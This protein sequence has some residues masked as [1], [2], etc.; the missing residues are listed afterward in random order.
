MKL[1]VT[2]FL[3]T[4]ETKKDDRRFKI[5]K[6]LISNKKD[7]NEK[8]I[9]DREMINVRRSSKNGML[10]VFIILMCGLVYLTMD[11]AK[12]HVTNVSEGK[13]Q[14][15]MEGGMPPDRPNN[16]D[17]NLGE[18]PSGNHGE[19]KEAGTP[20]QKPEEDF[21]G[22]DGNNGNDN[23]DNNANGEE[24]PE[25]PDG[26]MP[27]DN[28]M[29][30]GSMNATATLPYI[31]YVVFG[32]EGL[33]L[34]GL[35]MYLLL[36]NFNKKTRKQTF[37]NSDKVVIYLL[38]VV[39]L[40]SGFTYLCGKITKD[41]FLNSPNNTMNKNNVGGASDSSITYTS[42]KE[43]TE[44]TT[45]DSG[46]FSS[47]TKDEN[48]FLASGDIHA[49]LSNIT[50]TKSGDS[51][52][53]DNTSFYG[54]NSAIIAKDGANLTLKN[55]TIKAEATGANGVFSY[56]GSATTN[57]AGS[58]GTTV[59]IQDSNITTTKDN[60]GGIMTTGGGIMKASHLTV[61]TAGISSAAIRTDRGGGTVE[62]D[63]GTYTT[64]GQGSPSVYSTADITV[65]NAKLVS[66]SSEGIVIEGK[67]SVTMKSCELVDSNTKLNGK[68]TTYK[69]I[70]LYQSMSGD[71]ADGNAE[72]T[73]VDSTITT[74]NGDSF[75]VT[76]TT[77]TIHLE[78]NT[79]TNHDSNGN[80]LRIQKDSWG[81]TGKNGGE[82]T[83]EMTKQKI[84]GNIVV[85][86]ISTL[87]M[88][89][90]S[91]SY[92]EGTI[93]GSNS[94]KAVK[95]TLDKTSHIKLTGDS[96]VTSFEN[97]DSSNSNIDFNGYQLYVNGK[98]INE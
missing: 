20:P 87:D 98:A 97:S 52:G 3:L 73:S 10:L 15:G 45:I 59:T 72:F 70:F 23:K 14:N 33:V 4:K 69:N 49:T 63:G 31:Y 56:G 80:F 5:K 94:A 55:V 79:I 37:K 39:L 58:D 92:L 32:I 6:E 62:V 71:A 53:G 89:M 78:N 88:T 41:Y 42:V 1:G 2:I 13:I 44:D 7:K 34:S 30:M 95:L 46:E 61:Q 8:I 67:N 40:T 38:F 26:E 50:V 28:S 9:I 66:K 83:L 35:V 36:S 90:N 86:S 29:G 21:N 77:A 96:Y 16:G 81:T 11:Y 93:N 68:S 84:T 22:Q 18:P 76:N 60:S 82:V 17:S 27:N 48:V 57:N 64:T 51:D 85:D 75:Y 12:N 43:I 19:N 24:P 74:N 47:S 91:N 54:T 65:A 25:K